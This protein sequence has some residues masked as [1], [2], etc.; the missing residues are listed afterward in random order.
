[1]FLSEHHRLIPLVL[2]LVMLTSGCIGGSG[3]QVDTSATPD[4]T[5]SV[6]ETPPS[7]GNVTRTGPSEFPNTFNSTRIRV[8]RIGN[9]SMLP[10]G[11]IGHDYTIYNTRNT[12]REMTVTVW[13]NDSVVLWHTATYPADAS[14]LILVDRTGNYTVRIDPKNSSE[15]VFAAPSTFDCNERSLEVASL[16]NGG[17]GVRQ[18]STDLLCRTVVITPTRDNSSR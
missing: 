15:I 12:T 6:D 4:R 14:L 2:A 5:I 13:R 8:L 16:P 10:S 7:P 17:W 1:M 18:Y 11:V 9:A 3:G